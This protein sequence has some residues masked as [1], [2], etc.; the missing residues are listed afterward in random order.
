M[1][2]LKLDPALLSKPHPDLTVESKTND[3]L[4]ISVN[5]EHGT[6]SFAHYM[7][8]DGFLNIAR[9][10]NTEDYM[11]EEPVDSPV[12]W[13][14]FNPAGSI[15]HRLD[16]SRQ[17]VT[18]AETS[19]IFLFRHAIEYFIPKYTPNLSFVLC[20]TPE[21]FI[22]L[23]AE[24]LP[25][26]TRIIGAMMDPGR[27]DNLL[28]DGRSMTAGI[29]TVLEEIV[30]TPYHG[31]IGMLYREGKFCELLALRLA[32]LADNGSCGPGMR[33][34]FRLRGS[35]IQRVREARE[36]LVARIDD[37]PTTAELAR[38]VGINEF[39]LKKGFKHVF[40]TTIFEYLRNLRLE[41]AMGLI[42]QGDM[43]IARI[44]FE[45]GYHNP[46]HFAGA[47]R[48]R[49]GVNPGSLLVE[50]RRSSDSF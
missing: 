45:V 16:S 22:E 50:K 38:I 32:Q 31:R 17:A 39:K 5:S 15:S 48:R 42:K 18:R 24:F 20:L 8:H 37:P 6:G 3:E 46:A 1:N 21:R 11:I 25:R 49:F 14:H 33:G 13:F 28:I 30:H 47:F 34:S 9:N 44:A 7:F 19:N 29:R 12:V 43:T 23:S 40:N 4:H 27:S 41:T 35:E 2:R 26:S 10:H 36:T